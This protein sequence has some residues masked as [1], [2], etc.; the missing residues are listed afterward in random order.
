[1]PKAT[2]SSGTFPFSGISQTPPNLGAGRGSGQLSSW[3]FSSGARVVVVVDHLHLPDCSPLSL[4]PCLPETFYRCTV[5]LYVHLFG[6]VK[7]A[8]CVQLHDSS[9]NHEL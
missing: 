1:M 4:E 8:T 7:E 2:G 9:H 6:H 3:I 5:T